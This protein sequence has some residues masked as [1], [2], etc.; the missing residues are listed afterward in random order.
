VARWRGPRTAR[1]PL[2]VTAT[3]RSN[4]AYWLALAKTAGLRCALCG[5]AIAWRKEYHRL[6][7]GKENG[8]YLVVGHII[9][10]YAAKQMRWTEAQINA[11]SNSRPECKRCSNKTGAQL[12]RQLQHRKRNRT[13]IDLDTS[14]EW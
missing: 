6:P 11:L 13:R 10:R 4:R 9:S 5:C 8:N 7:N 1:D 14:R 3:H 2:L 12:G